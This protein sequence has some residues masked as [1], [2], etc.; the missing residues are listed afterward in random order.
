M[1]YQSLRHCCEDLEKK[2]QLL[3]IKEEL[4]PDLVI[5][6]L[7]RRIYQMKGPALLF[8]KV[9]NSPFQAVSNIFGTSERTFYL[10]EDVLKRFEWLIKV[11]IDPFSLLKN[12]GSSLRNLPW[13]FSAIPFKKRNVALQSIC[14]ISNLPKIR[15]WPKDG[16]SF[17]TLPQ[18][19]SFPPGSMNPKQANVGM[20][21]IQ[22]DGNDYLED[23]EIGLHYQLH[24]G[25][26]IHH[27]NHKSAQSKFQL[28]IG[29]GGP[30]A[31]S[32]ASIFP[33]PEGLSEILFSGLLN[34]RRYAYAIQ[35]G[36]FIP[37]DV[38]FCITGTVEDQVLK[39][40][41][42]FGDHL[43][44][45]SL[46][47][48]FPVLSHIKVWH[49]A[50]PLWHFTVVGRPPQ[51]DTSFGA[52][53]HS[54]VSELIGSEFPGIKAVHAVDVAGVHP[55]LLAIGSERYMP[56]R[57]R[58]PEEILTQANHLLGKGQTSLSKYLIIAA[59]NPDQVP[60]VHHIADFL[61][62]VLRRV[63]FKHDLHFYTHTTIDTLDYSGSGFNEGS[64]LVI[65]CNR[66]PLREL[67]NEVSL[68]TLLPTSFTKAR[69]IDHGIIAIESNAFSTY[70]FAEKELFE[71]TKFL[72]APQF[73]NFP[74]VVL[75]EDADFMAAD[76]SN[77]LWVTFTRS[78]P[79]HDV[80][81][82]RAS[83]QFKHWSC[84]APLIIDARKKPHHATVLEP[85][86]KTIREVDQIIYR[87]PELHKLFS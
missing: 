43:G 6:E 37:Q 18:V 33:L 11:K 76:F 59:S 21:R 16:G 47:H 51:E 22:L 39:E 79:S 67:S 60:D 65:S 71:L 14:S 26:G 53:I 56:F 86:P 4:D 55:L 69:L 35:D 50:D 70:E 81:G 1:T 77:F 3:R 84:D 41:G 61:K 74:L 19:I 68:F 34:S 20:Y 62:Y 31:F 23:Q 25:I 2:G 17:I 42:P 80:Y 72:D 27:Q 9:K 28:S 64:K 40:E 36:Y 10:F 45:Y 32:L 13:L 82:L 29:V 12:P 78:N 85:D 24:R 57:E 48:P 7:H 54:I 52:I 38:D 46:K 87:N 75:T 63:D 5:P 44:Y 49:K 8:E 58:K 83:H 15:A 30:P 73:E 66:D